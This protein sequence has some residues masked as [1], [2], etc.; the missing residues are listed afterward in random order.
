MRVIMAIF[1]G[2]M[3]TA[4]YPAYSIIPLL[5]MGKLQR[6]WLENQVRV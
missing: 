5:I 1:I 4:E 3:Y 6:R 2:A